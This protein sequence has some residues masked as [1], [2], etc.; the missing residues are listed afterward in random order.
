MKRAARYDSGHWWCVRDAHE[1]SYKLAVLLKDK[2]MIR[3]TV[4]HHTHQH[5][6]AAD[7]R[8]LVHCKLDLTICPMAYIVSRFHMALVM[9]EPLNVLALLLDAHPVTAI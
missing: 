1:S 7:N 2:P 5:L 3:L 4:H 9:L 6:Q 8:C